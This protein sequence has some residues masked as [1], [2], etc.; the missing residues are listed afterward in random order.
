MEY[1]IVTRPSA[2]NVIRGSQYGQV[3]GNSRAKT[4]YSH[5]GH[6]STV[7]AVVNFTGG[8]ILVG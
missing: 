8:N 4:Y 5:L 3:S 7:E 1:R 6:G 2:I